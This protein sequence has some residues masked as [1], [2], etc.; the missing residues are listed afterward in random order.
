VTAALAG[1][2][3]A[4]WVRGAESQELLLTAAAPI[5]IEGRTRGGVFL[6]QAGDQLL[7]LRDRAV[8]RLFNFTL[9]ATDRPRSSS[10]SAS[11]LG[12]ASA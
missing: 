11:P 3:H 6:E 1:R 2:S 12:S 8:T 9:L 5:V 7:A 10:C 4:E